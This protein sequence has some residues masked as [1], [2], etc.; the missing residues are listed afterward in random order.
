MS[1]TYWTA[2][3]IKMAVR[4]HGWEF[5]K[6][7]PA[8][9]DQAWGARKDCYEVIL[10]EN[11]RGGL[12]WVSFTHPV[13]G[14]FNVDHLGPRY[15]GKFE[16]VLQFLADPSCRKPLPAGNPVTDIRTRL[17][18]A[19]RKFML[20]MSNRNYNLDENRVRLD[21]PV[22]DVGYLADVLLSLPGIA[23]VELPEGQE[24]GESQTDFVHTRTDPRCPGEIAHF[25]RGGVGKWI[26]AAKAREYAAALLAAANAAEAVE[27][28][29]VHDEEMVENKI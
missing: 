21:S 1:P 29:Y 23:I 19:L 8:D 5:I 26:T 11:R 17:A 12:V 28:P 4:T 18:D 9:P 22:V 3:Q 25:L 16:E 14:G 2:S 10:K 24:W 20:S 27:V 15:R 6:A 13:S 7:R